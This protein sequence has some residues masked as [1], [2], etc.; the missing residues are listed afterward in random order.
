LNLYLD[1]SALVKL[2]VEEARSADVAAW[3]ARAARVGTSAVAY[4]EAR[5]ALARRNRDGGLRD[6]A[7]A[8]AVRDLDGDFSH[9]IAIPVTVELARRAG[10]LAQAHALRGFDAIHLASAEALAALLAKPVVVAAF[11]D[12]LSAAARALGLA[13]LPATA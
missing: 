4:A 3:T 5:A 1:T 9:A 11:D 7:L 6:E 12:R 10:E 8:G 13:T 2:Y